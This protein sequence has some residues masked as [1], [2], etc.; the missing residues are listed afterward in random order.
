[1]NRTFDRLDYLLT[2][3]PFK[4]PCPK[5]A[6][7]FSDCHEGD[8]SKA[9]DFDPNCNLFLKINARYKDAGFTR[10][11][12][13]D[14]WDRWQFPHVGPGATEIEAEFFIEGNHDNDL[15]LPEAILL[16]GAEYSILCVHGHQGDFWNDQAWKIG[17]F[18]T[19]QWK[20]FELVGFQEKW[21]SPSKNAK[22]HE[23]I[24]R[25]L[26]D[27]ANDR[28]IILVAG[29]IHTQENVGFYWN[30]GCEITPQ[31]IECIELIDGV[32]TLKSWG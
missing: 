22:R 21:F 20:Y 32:L 28:K 18:F 27:W 29:H 11:F 15:D 12:N 26:I 4:I 24:R 2:H 14:T 30:V 7:F 6:V 9:D 16:T 5:K 13:G 1:M 8:G 31:R 10:I 17:Q 3:P 25:D 19:H 23:L